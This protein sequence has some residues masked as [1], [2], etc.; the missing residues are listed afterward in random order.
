MPKPLATLRR[1]FLRRYP[2]YARTIYPLNATNA[3]GTYWRS[4]PNNESNE[5]WWN[6]PWPAFRGRAPL[7]NGWKAPD[8]V[9][10]PATGRA[11]QQFQLKPVAD[12]TYRQGGDV[13]YSDDEDVDD[14]E[15]DKDDNG[16]R[17]RKRKA[18][19][20]KKKQKTTA[21]V[22]PA[23]VEPANV[24]H[25]N[26][27]KAAA[28]R[29]VKKKALDPTYR[30]DNDV[31]YSDGENVDD[32]E[33]EKDTNG[34][35]KRKRKATAATPDPTYRQGNDVRYS[36]EDEDDVES[37]KDTNG[38]RKRKG[39]AITAK[40]KQKTTV[41][42]ETAAVLQPVKKRAPKKAKSQA[43]LL[44]TEAQQVQEGEVVTRRS[45]RKRQKT[46]KE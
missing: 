25:A 24:G 43:A 20:A 36:D 10:V 11:R 33:S 22:E 5:A 14:V 18:A 29:P 46:A 31:Q 17:K 6:I 1:K 30:Q 40:K 42:L 7:P 41:N 35:R 15:S 37:D 19:T 3:N 32:V 27:E 2:V 12:P 26:F 34:K 45:T 38:K 44:D 9:D 4:D 28:P 13:H 21:I 16:K 8:V 39:K 23:N